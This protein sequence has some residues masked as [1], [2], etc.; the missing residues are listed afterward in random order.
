MEEKSSADVASEAQASRTLERIS[1]LRDFK[2]HNFEHLSKHDLRTIDE[3][4]AHAL[5]YM[6]K[7]SSNLTDILVKI[8]KLEQMIDT[9]YNGL[10]GE[11][12]REGTE[13]TRFADQIKD[14]ACVYTSRVSNFSSYSPTKYF[15]SP[16]D[17][18]P[19]EI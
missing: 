17:M 12:F 14:Y 8:N 10:W 1:K 13:N 4:I 19:H 7:V 18:M 5:D 9:A 15:Q 11:L 2:L 16:K 6:S 3:E